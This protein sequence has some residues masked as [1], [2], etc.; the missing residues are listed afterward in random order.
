M[1]CCS[2]WPHLFNSFSLF[3]PS[4]FSGFASELDPLP[5]SDTAARLLRLCGGSS[6][7]VLAQAQSARQENSR[8]GDQ[9]AVTLLESLL[10]TP[11]LSPADLSRVRQAYADAL[12]SLAAYYTSANGRNYLLTCALEASEVAILEPSRDKVLFAREM[13][14]TVTWTPTTL[15]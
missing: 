15:L 1:H 3:P 6:A 12:R 7:S 11:S 9:W 4:R 13:K 10:L 2:L 5:R 8:S 14:S